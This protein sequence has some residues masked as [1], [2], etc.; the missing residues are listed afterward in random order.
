M[1]RYVIAGIIFAVIIVAVVVAKKP[2]ERVVEKYRTIEAV[3]SSAINEAQRVTSILQV[4]QQQLAVKTTDLQDL[5]KRAENWQSEKKALLADIS[6]L[7]ASLTSIPADT[8]YVPLP[9]QIKP[10]T[11]DSALIIIGQQNRYITY[12]GEQLRSLTAMNI[13]QGV[14]INKQ[15]LVIAHQ[16]NF[17]AEFET[18]RKQYERRTYRNI[19]IAFIAGYVAGKIF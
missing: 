19:G 2:V 10:E 13:T 17:I 5:E 12:Q 7:K 14:I 3:A 1:K 4:V 11:L 8:V 15:D 6:H 9:P 16:D 18:L